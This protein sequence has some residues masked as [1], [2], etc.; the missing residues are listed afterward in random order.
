MTNYEEYIEVRGA[1]EHNLKNIDVTIPRE[2]LVVITGL[3]GSGKSSLAFD[4]IYAEGQRRYIE[5]FSAYA[6]QF[7]G[8]L[9]RPDVDKIDGLSPVI[10]IEQKTTSKSPRSTVGTITEI[11]DFLRL[12]F[13]RAADAYSYN[14]G[15]KMVSYSDEQIKELIF[16]D[17]SGKRINVLSPVIRSRKGHYRELFEQISKQGFVKVRLDGEIRDIEKGMKAD[18]YKTHDIEIVIDRLQVNPASEEVQ[19]RL[20]ETINTAMY[21]GDDVL[22]IIDHDSKEVRYFSRNLMCPSSGISYPKPE[23]NT[24]SFNSPKGMCSK[25]SGLG[26]VHEVNIDKVIPDNKR[27]IKAG[28]IEPLGAYKKSWMFKQLETIAERFNFKLT[29]PID[30]IPTDAMQVIL[31]GGNERFS[32]ASKTLG[33]TKDYKIEFEGIISFITNQFN[34]SSSTSIKRWAKGFMDK[35]RCPVCDGSRLKKESLN[36]KVNKKNIAELAEMDISDLGN[37]FSKLPKS[38]SGTQLKIAEEVVKEI[39]TRIRFLLDVGLDYLSLNRSSKSLS[40]G[41]AQRIRLATQIGSQLVGVLYILDEPSIGLHQRDN[42]RLIKSLTA[43]R[44]LGNSVIVVEHD[45]DMIEQADHVI[46]IGPEAGKHGGEIISQGSPAEIK[47]FH[48]LTADYLNGTKQ[49]EI[50]IK[51]RKGN[52]NTL[53]L[54]GCTGN[55]LKNVTVKMPL[56]K[57]IGVTGVSGSGKSTL[58]NETLYPILNAHFFNAVKKPMPYKSIQGLKHIDKVIDINQSPIGRTPRSNPATYTGVFSEIR[59]LF[60]KTPE[61]MIRGYKPGRFSFNVK[62][63]RCVTCEGAGLRVIEMNFLPDVYVECETCQGKRFNRE[64]LE[65]RYKGKSIS[66][67]LN[68]TIDEAVKFFENIPKIHRKLKTIKDVGLGYITLGQQSTTLSGGEAQRIK[69][70]TELSKKDTGNTFYILDEPTTGLHFE[71]IR[72]LMEVL[73]KLVDKGNTVLIIEHNLDVIKTVDYII[74]IG[75]EGGKGGGEVVAEGTPEKVAKDPKSYTAKFL[76]KELP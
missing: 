43:L 34:E 60:T 54:K 46:D 5:T 7:L 39:N 44:D 74:D 32:V 4:T 35:N 57:M 48:T 23:P 56:G 20:M 18:R 63:G 36:F 27:S 1:R 72:V 53:V 2:R 42:E 45:K 50:P 16:Q 19:K 47:T 71:D 11:Y 14:T 25:C 29:D 66:D 33:V 10:A 21:H 24:F 6:R 41:E 75:Y 8:G 51:R 12:L 28:G 52:G 59:T 68:M 62:G 58:I 30:K 15:E 13:A 76:K 17:F 26:T 9:E 3:S 37:W 73:N 70:A 22:M 67:I 61:A 64:T 49:I 69:L 65:I 55:N 31:H 38:L 40:G